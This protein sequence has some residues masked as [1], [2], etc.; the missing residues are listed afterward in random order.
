MNALTSEN[1]HDVLTGLSIC[2]NTRFKEIFRQLARSKDLGNVDILPTI[3]KSDPPEI[4]IDKILEKV[5]SIYS[6]FC[7]VSKWN[8]TKKGG[9]GG[10]RKAYKTGA[11]PSY[12]DGV[13]W[14]YCEKGCRPKVCK[15]P[16]D[17]AQQQ[18]CYEA[19]KKAGRPKS[20]STSNKKAPSVASLSSATERQR[21]VWGDSGIHMHNGVLM[22]NARPVGG[23]YLLTPPKR[24][25][26][27]P[28]TLLNSVYWITTLS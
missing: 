18:R 26:N 12:E 28:R 19:W 17:K 2:N 24:M 15:K 13:C 25:L 22:A 8:M 6:M 5:V 23:L 4:Q 11:E 10:G 9:G 20:G 14:N 21:K 7:K 27:G 1:E 16:E 3:R